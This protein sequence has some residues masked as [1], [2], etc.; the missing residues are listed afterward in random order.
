MKKNNSIEVLPLL[1]LAGGFG[2]RLQSV[3]DGAPKALAPV[4][5]KP[6]LYY[7]IDHW[8]KQGISSFIF[9]LHHHSDLIIAFLKSEEDKLLKN[10]KI[11]YVYEPKPMGTGGAVAYAIKQLSLNGDFLLTNA[12]TWLGFAVSEIMKMPSPAI[13]VVKVKN[14]GRFGQVVYNE[15]RL[16]TEFIEKKINPDFGWINAGISRMNTI[17]FKEWDGQPFS[18][19]HITYPQLALREI[20]RAVDLNIDF[21][22][23]GVPDDYARFCRWVESGKTIGL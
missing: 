17:F 6:F 7:Q 11:Q 16:V 20:L 2:L 13:L 1:V 4:H 12:D 9:L 14:V 5:G 22:D 19:E 21:I 8:I 10:C 23:I 3:L 15:Q 18:L